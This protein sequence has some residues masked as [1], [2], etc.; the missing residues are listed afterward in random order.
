MKTQVTVSGRRAR[1][2]LLAHQ[3]LLA[4][5]QRDGREL[6]VAE[7]AAFYDG[8]GAQCAFAIC[9]GVDYQ[10][11]GKGPPDMVLHGRGF[12]I[13]STS[14]HGAGLRVDDKRDRRL[15]ETD[16]YVLMESLGAF[17]YRWI[18]WIHV[19]GTRDPDVIRRITIGKSHV[20]EVPRDRLHPPHELD[21]ELN[22]QQPAIG[23][24]AAEYGPGGTVVELSLP[25]PSPDPFDTP[26]QP[27]R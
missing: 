13:R 24:R 12:E 4:D 9:M 3:S 19:G 14:N 16:I 27:H 18:G 21:G 11:P 10:P 17:T 7:I 26:P 23:S 2:V 1:E 25:P 20:Y 5:F 22:R 15:H 6:T 8:E